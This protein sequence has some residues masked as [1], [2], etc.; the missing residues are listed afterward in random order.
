[1]F[2]KTKRKI[3]K[4]WSNKDRNYV[5]SAAAF[6]ELPHNQYFKGASAGTADVWG[7][8]AATAGYGTAGAYS[9]YPADYAGSA[10][11]FGTQYPYVIFSAK[12]LKL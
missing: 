11:A 1:M 8:S 9:S 10:A 7:A 12:L 2:T 6:F 5:I 4:K 3:I